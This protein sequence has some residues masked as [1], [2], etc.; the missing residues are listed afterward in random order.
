MIFQEPPLDHPVEEKIQWARHYYQ[1][2][3][4]FLLRDEAV[5]ALLNQFEKAAR[6]SREAMEAAGIMDECRVCEEDEGG[7]C[8]G[9]GL[10]NKYSAVLLLTNLLLGRQLPEKRFDPKGCFFL[11]RTGCS[12]LARHV[13][14]VNYLCKKI[15]DGIP[16]NVIAD[17]REKEGTE[18]QIL[19]RIHERI[20]DQLRAIDE[21]TKRTIEA[22]ARFYDHKMV[23]H[24]GPLGFRRS[25]DLTRLVECLCHLIHQGFLLPGKSLFLDMG[26][27]DGRV[28]V[29]L[30]Y[31][32]QS[33]IGIEL[34]EW[35]LDEYIPLKKELDD[36]L[37]GRSLLIPP[38]NI[39][40]FHGDSLDK[41]LQETILKKTGLGFHDFHL[42]YTY[43]TMHEEFAALIAQKA[44]KGAV[45]MVYGLDKIIP[46][47]KGLTL[48]TP[49][50]PLAGVI[51]LYQK[52]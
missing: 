23:G 17:L 52:P 41:G 39:H 42:F 28:N 34:D 15:I 11:G 29:L 21:K 38:D 10:E 12:L 49:D 51:A 47:F 33:S 1:L 36:L 26:C 4:D 48:L 7:S 50:K 37:Q 35:T 22:V 45:F 31:L 14:C 5:H 8:C 16:S 19:F 30:S 3:K 24:L 27:G 43:L 13:I 40:L 20:K 46:R 6:L 18:L 25:T 9:A 2:F 44:R 32:V